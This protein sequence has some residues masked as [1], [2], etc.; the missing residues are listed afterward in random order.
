M[1]AYK[2]LNSQDL[3]V[4]PF[5]VNKGF[6]FQGGNALT[7]SDVQIGR[8]LGR[9][10]DYLISGSIPGTGSQIFANN[11]NLPGTT[12]FPIVLTLLWK[13]HIWKWWIYG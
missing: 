5:E 7:G 9:S 2:Q 4:S 11:G 13:L 1:S 12:Q 6:Y 3:I 8:Y 10:G